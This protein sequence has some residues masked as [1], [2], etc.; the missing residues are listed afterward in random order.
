MNADAARRVALVT[1]GRRGIGLGIARALAA[2]GF[3]LAVCGVSADPGE[4]LAALAGPGTEVFY[5]RCD[6]ATAADRAR[7]LDAVRERFGRLHVLVNN[8]G[9]APAVR[10]DLLE[11]TES[12]FEHVLRTNLQGPFF[13]TQAVARWMLAQCG[14]DPSWCGCIVNVTSISATAA[15]VRRGEYCISK[16][17]AAMASKLWAARLAEHGIPVYEVRPGI[18][19]TDMTAPVRE[20]YDRRI[21]EGLVPQR[22]WGEPEDVGRAVAMLARGDLG[23]ST[24]AVIYVDGG[25]SIER[26]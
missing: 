18:I 20:L 1:G 13:L 9:I 17:G 7:L 24:G 8:A 10:A 23:F 21:A 26:L 22:R 15:S 4:G 11:M 12:S 16:A 5:V 14:E 2:E 6:V 3:D 25:F 19:R